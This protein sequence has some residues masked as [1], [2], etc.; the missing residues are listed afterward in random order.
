MGEKENFVSADLL[1]EGLFKLGLDG[2]EGGRLYSALKRYIE[3]IELFNPAYGLVKVRDR[4]E[5]IVKHIL[6]SLAPL[7]ILRR[8]LETRP[9]AGQIADVGSG[10]GVPGIPLAI[11]MPGVEFTLIERMGR[12]AG[13]LRN[14]LAVLDLPNVRLE[15]AE[16]E[17]LAQSSAADSFDLIVFRAFKPLDSAL[18]KG[19]SR[20][21][22]P[23]G[24]I[25][26]YKGRR[27]SLEEEMARLLKET[28]KSAGPSIADWEVL[29]LEV[30]FLEEE[31]HL[32]VIR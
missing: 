12:R 27:E 3:E 30:P 29:P 14:T 25:A 31:R 9:S 11:C 28:E 6:D 19:L 23:G 32:L 26:A 20:L 8:L 16:M 22:A 21:L 2:E 24:I 5:L 17:S 1:A 15:E 18:L 4:V 13:F 10:A 7:N